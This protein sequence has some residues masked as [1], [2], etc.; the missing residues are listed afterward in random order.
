MPRGS[1]NLIAVDLIIQNLLFQFKKVF[2]SGEV[3]NSLLEAKD[4]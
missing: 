4:T 1:S 3:Q 2:N